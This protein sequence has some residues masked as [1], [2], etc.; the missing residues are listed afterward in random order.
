MIYIER[1]FAN[2]QLSVFVRVKHFETLS[3][4]MESVYIYFMSESLI[5]SISEKF[6]GFENIFSTKTQLLSSAGSFTYQKSGP[7]E[8]IEEAAKHLLSKWDDL[9]ELFNEFHNDTS[10]LWASRISEA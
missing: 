7:E 6:M 3:K 4:Y 8:K 2:S 1:P 5:K 9:I 10:A